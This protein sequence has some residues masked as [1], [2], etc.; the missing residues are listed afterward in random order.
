M[1][2]S[3]SK[4]A[5]ELKCLKEEMTEAV[6]DGRYGSLPLTKLGLYALRQDEPATQKYILARVLEKLTDKIN[7]YK[8]MLPETA[9]NEMQYISCAKNDIKSGNYSCVLQD[10]FSSERNSYM[11]E[12]TM[13][14]DRRFRKTPP[15][16]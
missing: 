2:N 11:I 3:L 1:F 5:G 4:N 9:E 7:D 16:S 8:T 13:N 14:S 12:K 6:A 15:S 10:I